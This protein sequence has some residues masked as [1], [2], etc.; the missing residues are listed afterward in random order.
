MVVSRDQRHGAHEALPGFSLAREHAAAFGCQRVE[1]PAA[2]PRFLDPLALQPAAFLEPIQQWIQR[3]GV[4]LQLAARARPDELADLV[5][6][7][8]PR[9]ENRQDDELRGALLQLA[10]ERLDRWHSH[11]CYNRFYRSGN[12]HSAA[13]GRPKKGSAAISRRARSNAKARLCSTAARS[14]TP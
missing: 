2:L 13:F 11:I 1:A 10:I 7:A 3:R 4:K 14:S 5:A 6:V 9:L 8:W 12:R